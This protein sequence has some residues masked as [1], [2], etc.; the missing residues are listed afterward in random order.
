MGACWSRYGE[1]RG[2]S[3]CVSRHQLTRVSV[4]RTRWLNPTNQAAVEFGI[5]CVGIE[6][7]AKF[8]DRAVRAAETAGVAHLVTVRHADAL[9]ETWPE[10][11]VVFIYLTPSGIGR[12][13]P[14]LERALEGGA[15]VAASV[16]SVRARWPCALCTPRT[17]RR[18][19]APDASAPAA[20][21]PRMDTRIHPPCAGI[22]GVLVSQEC[23]RWRRRW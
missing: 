12:A 6:Y 9:A 8:A 3:H 1:V 2:S 19:I 10:C 11:S 21:G 15:R 23:Q 13:R 4:P 5:Q 20:P 14:Q 17:P 18:D 16:F 22:A 7:D